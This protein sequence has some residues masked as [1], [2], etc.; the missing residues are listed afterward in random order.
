MRELP[1]LSGAP[2]SGEA[3]AP[4]EDHRALLTADPAHVPRHRRVHLEVFG[5]QMN[6]LD[7]ELLVSALFDEGYRLT[8]DIR[9]AGV[10]L[11][12]TCAVREHAENRVFSKVGALKRIKEND[13]DTVIGVL[14][15]SAQNHGAAICKRY[16]HVGIVCGPGEFLRVPE[17]IGEARTGRRVVLT[18]LRASPE[19]ARSQNLGANVYQAYVAVMRGCDQACTFCVVPHT[20]GREV[21]RPVREIVDEARALVDAGVREITLLGQTVNSYGKRLAKNHAIGLQHVLHELQKLQGLERIRFITSHPKYVTP[22]LID[23]MATLPKVC[24]YLHL[25]IQSGSDAVLRRMLRNYTVDHYRRVVADCHERIQN[26]VLATDLIVG[27]CG[28]TDE[29]FQETVRLVEDLRFHGAFIFKYSERSGTRAAHLYADDVPDAVKRERNQILL[30]L[31]ERITLGRRRERIGSVQEVLVEG[32][33]K[34]DSARWTGRT[35]GFEI[36][37]F[38]ATAEERLEGR[39]VSVRIVDA[40]P[41]VLVGDR[42]GDGR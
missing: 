42:V 37:V 10:I 14:G 16:P 3:A 15:C 32:P 18:D 33:S 19:R 36:V 25:P 13:P 39:L 17:L 23:A 2:A 27:F 11:F 24:E 41:L 26:L 35:R 22:E 5:C 38:P 8:D 12:H 6:K 34:L 1:V 9:D 40:T 30:S 4:R 28:E 21:S 31:M 20:R 7:A 29:E